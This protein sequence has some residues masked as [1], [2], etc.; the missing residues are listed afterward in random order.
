MS[1]PVVLS[2]AGSDPS[3]GAGIQADIKTI[4]ANGCYA[5]SIA[6]TE[7]IQNSLG[8]RGD[9][10]LPSKLI[11]D[12]FE[13]LLEDFD[14]K[15]IKI[16]MLRGCEQIE[17]ISNLLQN[18]Q[19][20]VV[21]DPIIQTSSGREI[22]GDEDLECL[23]KLFHK[24]SLLTPNIDE[25]EI[26]STIKIESYE[27]MKRAVKKIEAKNILLKGGHLKDEILSDL[28]FYNKKLYT[29]SHPRVDTKNTHGTG[30]T[31]SSAIA[32]FIAKGLELQEAVE[33]A[34]NYLQNSLKFAYDT[35]RGD[36][37]LN[38]FFMLERR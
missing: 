35:G 28:L 3:G 19:I 20:P 4:S 14:I 2:I 24:V 37:S 34:I 16:G 30:C 8:L 23:K 9:F 31:L 1:H 5:L 11:R 18:L 7:T 17:L 38:H 29:F 12:Q 13:A 21:L 6:T 10:I 15:A 27:D 22:L 36:G 26:L 32:C 25:A 33:R